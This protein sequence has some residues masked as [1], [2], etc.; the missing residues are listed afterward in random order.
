VP[1]ASDER[2]LKGCLLS[3]FTSI[4]R[5]FS[6]ECSTVEWCLVALG[7]RLPL[8]LASEEGLVLVI[9]LVSEYDLGILSCD[10]S[11][12]EPS[13][14]RDLVADDR[15]FFRAEGVVPAA[16]VAPSVLGESR[17]LLFVCVTPE[18]R[19]D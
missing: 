5:E 14:V 9:S 17:A 19:C 6:D 7:I 13:S 10:R 12:A 18:G 16:V 15:T 8:R 2:L 4:P 11:V 1:S 3:P